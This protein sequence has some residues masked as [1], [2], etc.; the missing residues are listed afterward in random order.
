MIDQ[1]YQYEVVMTCGGCSG[2]VT[3]ALTRIL[4]RAF[5]ATL[6]PH[7]LPPSPFVHTT[8]RSPLDV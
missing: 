7:S 4:P 8:S 6:T 3:R 2:A 5:H 1:A